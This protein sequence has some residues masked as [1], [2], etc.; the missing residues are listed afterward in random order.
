MEARP[1]FFDLMIEIGFIVAKV[2]RVRCGL[3]R[4][5]RGGNKACS[6]TVMSTGTCTVLLA[7]PMVIAARYSPGARPDRLA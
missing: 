5:K 4:R 1:G 7:E 6:A 3:T 2:Y